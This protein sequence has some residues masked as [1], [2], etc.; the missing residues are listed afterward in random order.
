[1]MKKEFGKLMRSVN[2]NMVN[3]L[4]RHLN[5]FTINQGQIDYFLLIMDRPG[6]N[7]LDIAKGKNVGKA[8]VTKALKILEEDGLIRRES[9][10]YDR[11]NIKCFVTDKGKEQ[12]KEMFKL[13]KRVEAELFA[14][15]SDDELD[16]FY[17]Y[18]ER[19]HANSN[20]LIEKKI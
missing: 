18:L 15:F 3:F 8:S 9:D 1:M 2:A 7:Q 12:A 20:S 11:R 5:D 4:N 19:L 17:A 14:G 10:P 16:A 6:I 13:K